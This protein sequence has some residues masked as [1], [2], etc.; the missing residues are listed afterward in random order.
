MMSIHPSS[1]RR[2][3]S[4]FLVR[5]RTTLIFH[6]RLER[7]VVVGSFETAGWPEMRSSSSWETRQTVD[8]MEGRGRKQINFD[9]DRFPHFHSHLQR[10]DRNDG[11][12]GREL[13]LEL[14]FGQHAPCWPPP[15]QRLVDVSTCF[16]GF[17]TKF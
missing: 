7:R 5:R 15:I 9:E 14:I 11:L 4:K 12:R 17:E 3:S 10:P 13:G 1:R 2:I 6:F 16:Y 8:N